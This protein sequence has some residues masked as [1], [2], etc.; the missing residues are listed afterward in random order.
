MTQKSPGKRDQKIAIRKAQLMA[1][2]E[3]T[4]GLSLFKLAINAGLPYVTAYRY[5]ERLEAEGAIQIK[6]KA[7]SLEIIPAREGN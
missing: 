6:R 2:I 1:S 7:S 3:N 4:P 5:M